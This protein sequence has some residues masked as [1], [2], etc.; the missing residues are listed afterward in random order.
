[1]AIP[2]FTNQEEWLAWMEAHPYGEQDE[3]GFDLGRLRENVR[4]APAERV[5]QFAK[6]R[7]LVEALRG[8]ARGR[9]L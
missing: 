9:S 5:A 4:M 6:A 2:Q 3:N 1:M 7:R 8:A